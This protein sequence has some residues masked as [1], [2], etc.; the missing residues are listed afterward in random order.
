MIEIGI[1]KNNTRIIKIKPPL[2]FLVSITNKIMYTS[3]TSLP[4]K[5]KK[6]FIKKMSIEQTQFA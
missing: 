2:K 3:A 5:R 1:G 4:L 6:V